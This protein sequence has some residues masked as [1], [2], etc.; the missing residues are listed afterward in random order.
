MDPILQLCTLEDWNEKTKI[1]PPL[2]IN[3]T[4]LY[5]VIICLFVR[6]ELWEKVSGFL[7]RFFLECRI[8]RGLSCFIHSCASFRLEC[9]SDGQKNWVLD[10][11]RTGETLHMISIPI[12]SDFFVY[13][14]ISRTF[15]PVQRLAPSLY[16]TSRIFIWTTLKKPVMFLSNVLQKKIN[17]FGQNKI[18]SSIYNLKI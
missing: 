18:Y 4:Y 7:R 15:M 13:M 9:I 11:N 6:F 5:I 1:S 10:F 14:N 12:L 2:F 3:N 17:F 16:I 8:G